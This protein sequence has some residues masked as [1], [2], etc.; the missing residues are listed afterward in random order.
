LSKIIVIGSGFA[1]LSAAC[2]LAKQGEQV[3]VIE[4][5]EQ[6]GGRARAFEAAGFTYDM[7]PSWYWMPDVFERFFQQFDTTHEAFYTLKRLDPSYQVIWEDGVTKLPADFAAL[8]QT[9]EEIEPGAGAQLAAFMKE[10]AYKYAASMNSLV[11][12]PGLSITE[13]MTREVISSVFKIDLFQSMHHHVRKYFKHPKLIQLAEFPVLFLGALPKN[14]P[15][16]YSMMNYAD[17][18]LGTWYPMG[19]MVEIVKAMKAVAERLGVT[20][21]FNEPVEQLLVEQMKVTGVTT[22]KATYKADVVVM[23]CDYAHADQKLTPAPYRNYSEAYWD[24]RKMA[25]SSLLYYVGVNKPVEGLLHH[26]LFFDASFEQ[27]AA[28][29]Y[30]DAQW[31]KKPLMYVCCPSK[32]DSTVAPAGQENLFILIPVAPGMSDTEQIKK[33]Y[34]DIAIARIEQRTGQEIRK[35]IVYQRSYAHNDFVQDYNAYKGNAYGLANT[36]MQTAVLKPSIRNKKLKNLFYAGQLTVPGP[37]VPPSLISG[38]IVAG[39]VMKQL[40]N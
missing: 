21:K 19:G 3:T 26:N 34:F 17:M 40:Y 38:E 28:E 5:N 36:L 32:T 14:T 11:Y 9:F 8:Q 4:K 37:G 13:F 10:A 23:A 16:L 30:T 22:N 33:D 35:H 39:Q 6:A 29:L 24:K 15:A 7:G 25:P 2:F 20:F 27:H 31:P 1:G 12:K 18:K